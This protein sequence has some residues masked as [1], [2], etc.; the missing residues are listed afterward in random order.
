MG[1]ECFEAVVDFIPVNYVP[2]C[3]EVF[4]AAIVVLQIISMLP[5]VVAENGEQALGDW[6]VLVGRADDL[7][8]AAGFAG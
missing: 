6:I 3:R 7:Y 2:P 5:N 8:L 4:G 1:L